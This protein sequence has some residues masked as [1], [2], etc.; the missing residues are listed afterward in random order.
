MGIR[1]KWR[2]RGRRSRSRELT[3]QELDHV[4]E[5]FGS[6]FHGGIGELG[7]IVGGRGGGGEVAIRGLG[8]RMRKVVVLVREG[9]EYVVVEV[10]EV[11]DGDW[12]VG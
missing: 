6:S 2:I 10:H 1:I 7:L 5:A 8:S 3:V 9:G 11:S 12:L 4:I